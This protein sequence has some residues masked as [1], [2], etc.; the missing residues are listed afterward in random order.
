MTYHHLSSNSVI[1][2]LALDSWKS[3]LKAA[4][5]ANSVAKASRE[6]LSHIAVAAEAEAGVLLHNFTQLNVT[7]TAVIFTP[8]T[9][10]AVD[11]TTFTNFAD[12]ITPFT[13]SAL[14]H[15]TVSSF[16]CPSDFAMVLPNITHGLQDATCG[17]VDRHQKSSGEHI[18]YRYLVPF[19]PVIH[20]HLVS[21]C[22]STAPLS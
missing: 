22:S 2:Q 14:H 16:Q 13:N 18:V 20:D 10:S 9:Y 6:S 12:N 3:S 1:P 15:D 17:T 4:N 19:K 11:F 21:A 7:N 8:C 5:I